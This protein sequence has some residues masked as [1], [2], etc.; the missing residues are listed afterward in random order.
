MP[1]TKP[2]T[3]IISQ[4][5]QMANTVLAEGSK[6]VIA[7]GKPALEG[8]KMVASK[9]AK[10]ATNNPTL[11]ATTV[12]SVAVVAAPGLVVAPVLSVLGF[13][14]GGIKAYSLAAGAQSA[15]GNVAAGSTFA[16]LQSAA[17][18]GYGIAAVNG[19][20]QVGGAV[21]GVGSAGLRWVRAKL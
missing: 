12:C 9:T 4:G 17:A 2:S 21:V 18:G 19:V 15:M 1:A 10:W 11:A 5:A 20:A 16:T 7:Y 14:S 3:Q 8:S 13:G 6:I